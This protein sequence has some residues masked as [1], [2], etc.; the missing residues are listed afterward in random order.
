MNKCAVVVVLFLGLGLA[1]CGGGSPVAMTPSVAKVT[2][3]LT[4]Q[5]TA[6]V[7]GSTNAGG[8]WSVNGIPGGN[9]TVGTITSAG[10]Y[11][12]P[13][14]IPSGNI[15]VGFTSSSD[16]S[17]TSS[18]TLEPS[19]YANNF[20]Y[21]QNNSDTQALEL[22][23]AGPDGEN[24]TQILIPGGFPP[25][26]M[27]NPEDPLSS[28]SVPANAAV[29]AWSPEH[30]F[31]LFQDD[32]RAGVSI[33]EGQ[34]YLG[35]IGTDAAPTAISIIKPYAVPYAIS[36][37]GSKLLYSGEQADALSLSGYSGLAIDVQ[38]LD[39]SNWHTVWAATST[40]TIPVASWCGDSVLAYADPTDWFI[41]TVN[42]DGT[43]LNS[44][45]VLGLNA[46]CSPDGKHIAFNQPPRLGIWVM[47]TDGSNLQKFSYANYSPIWSPDGAWIAWVASPTP[48]GSSLYKIP[49]PYPSGSLPVPVLV[50]NNIAGAAWQ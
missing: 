26:S 45:N 15:A 40:D 30:M 2:V 18:V 44:T 13:K 35:N 22:W 5:F 1:G 31:Y 6:V 7:Q 24:P 36:P 48:A 21:T 10:L 38:G 11:T 16:S 14:F 19:P 28:I 29:I 8:S 23:T 34:S 41:K 39:G 12:A 17:A 47:N 37:D 49:F 43:G 20:L 4:Q 3:T 42:S 9:A 33:S 27:L 32:L 50:M 46:A 25:V